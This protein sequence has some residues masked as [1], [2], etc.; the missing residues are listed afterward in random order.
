MLVSKKNPTWWNTVNL[1]YKKEWVVFPWEN[2]TNLNKE[3]KEYKKKRGL[4]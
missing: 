1:F 3:E 4:K 2:K